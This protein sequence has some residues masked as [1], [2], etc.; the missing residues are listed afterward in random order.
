MKSKRLLTIALVFLSIALVSSCKKYLDKK[1]DNAFTVPSTITDFQALLDDISTMNI[2]TA[3]FG[4][5]SDDDYFLLQSKFNSLVTFSQNIYTWVPN[6]NTVWEN[7]WSKLYNPIYNANLSLEGLSKIPVTSSNRNAWNNVK[8]SALFFRAYFFLQAAWTYSKAYDDATADKD[9]GIVLRMASDFNV[10]SVRAN[11]KDSYQQIIKDALEAIPYLPDNPVHPMR[12]S[13]PAAYGLLARAYLSMRQ[14]DNAFKYADSCLQ[15]KNQLINYNGDPDI[16]GN[17][18]ANAP[19]KPFNKEVIFHSSMNT[20]IIIHLPAAGA[21]VD[22]FLYAS[23][24]SND[25]RK[26]AFFAKSGLYQKYKGNYGTS[27][28]SLFSGIATN[29]MMLVRAE[30]YARKGN[31]DAALADLNTLL[32]N[33]FDNT[34]IPIT[35]TDANDALSKILQERRKELLLRG[36]RWVDIKRLNKEGANITPKRFENNQ[37]YTL[38]PNANYYALPIPGDIITLTGIPQNPH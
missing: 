27:S 12:P 9:L 31:K 30:C 13:K 37:T 1:S 8:G 33:R 20:D 17:L 19:F 3:E 25:L 18:T 4:E 7:D 14:Y 38:L 36:L 15:K 28:S 34:F 35:A 11:V 2:V 21:L 16:N 6:A 26:K 24:A 32:A 23:Y 22:T 10:P 29:E 5:A